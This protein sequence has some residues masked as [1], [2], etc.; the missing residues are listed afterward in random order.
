MICTNLRHAA[1]TLRL[2]FGN[3]VQGGGFGGGY[4]HFALLINALN[5]LYD[6]EV[7]VTGED[8]ALKEG[9]EVVQAA[10]HPHRAFD[11]FV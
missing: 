8:D 11:K 9:G 6:F 7:A 1:G 10:A 3:A 4:P 2:C 5:A